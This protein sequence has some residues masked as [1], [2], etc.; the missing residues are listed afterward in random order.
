MAGARKWRTHLI[1]RNDIASLTDECAKVTAI[2]Y[3]MDAYREEALAIID[4]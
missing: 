4:N 1:T 3:I 2:P